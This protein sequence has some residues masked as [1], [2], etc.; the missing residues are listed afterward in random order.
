MKPP[1]R[2]VAKRGRGILDR[3]L[4]V[5]YKA[6]VLDIISERTVTAFP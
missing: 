5:G 1:A 2:N 4:A 6:R 3:V